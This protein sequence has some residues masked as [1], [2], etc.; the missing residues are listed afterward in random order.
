MQNQSSSPQVHKSFK[1]LFFLRADT[2]ISKIRKMPRSATLLLDLEDSVPLE[3]KAVQRARIKAI[4]Q[5]GVMKG[6]TTFLRINGPDEA[7]LMKED[8]A[9]CLHQDL[10]GLLL[11]M[12]SN[13]A[14]IVK[15]DEIVTV[16]EQMHGLEVG[17]IDFIPL[18]ERPGGALEASA[19]AS[20][21]SRNVAL[22][23]GHYDF[24][25]EMGVDPTEEAIQV[26]R[27][28]VLMAAKAHNLSAISTV[29]TE[30]DNLEGFSRENQRMKA[31]G[32]DGCFALTP[33]QMHAALEIFSY[34]QEQIDHA[35]RVIQAIDEQGSIAKLDGVMIGPPILKKAKKIMA[36]VMQESREAA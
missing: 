1:S 25:M 32:F 21:S 6:R 36:E 19:I 33:K 4:F 10:S 29:Y 9:T 12:V 23:F 11:P 34:S 35:R 15:I 5:S 22:A 17:A 20:A 26:A 16:A 18:I 3:K 2:P 30:L 28:M 31:L 14:E 27:S 8:I 24:C 13:A 7:E